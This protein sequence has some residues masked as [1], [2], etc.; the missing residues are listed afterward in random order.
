M[1]SISFLTQKTRIRLHDNI[2]HSH[3]T[4]LKKKVQYSLVTAHL[5]FGSTA[6]TSLPRKILHECNAIAS[7]ANLSH[8]KTHFNR[9]H[10]LHENLPMCIAIRCNNSQLHDL[11]LTD[12]KPKQM[13]STTPHSQDWCAKEQP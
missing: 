1:L 2:P 13:R 9:R 10:S 6:F 7:A 3:V 12:K 5:Q 8:Y 4:T 11:A